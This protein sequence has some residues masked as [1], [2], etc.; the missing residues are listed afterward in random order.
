MKEVED[1]A[2]N[3][4]T[5]WEK[6]LQKPPQHGFGDTRLDE[7]SGEVYK[8]TYAIKKVTDTIA[9]TIK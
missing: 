4:R 1:K 7:E 6:V 5:E 3:A 2:A 8:P 9:A